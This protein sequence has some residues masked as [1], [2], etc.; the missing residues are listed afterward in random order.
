MTDAL[1]SSL[2][3]LAVL[4][5]AALV[6]LGICGALHLVGVRGP[7]NFVRESLDGS[8]LWLAA[9]VAV[10][11]TGGSLWFSEVAGYIPCKL[12]WFQR[13]AMYPLV[14]LVLVALARDRRAARYF[15]P[16]PLVGLGV[17]GWHLLVER[18]VVE[19][20]Q[21]CLISAPGGCATR[22]I[23]ELGYVTIPVL[24]ATAFAAIAVLLAFAWAGSRV[25][26]AHV[27]QESV[28]PARRGP[29]RVAEDT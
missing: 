25:A 7:W 27:R 14:L 5:Q 3:V 26:E 1:T 20:T 10:V 4:G 15:L 8:E 18:G 13:I 2:A 16:L 24:A 6:A 29:R 28:E 22:W 17:A 21:S 19:D 23:E 12:C 9:L 11:A